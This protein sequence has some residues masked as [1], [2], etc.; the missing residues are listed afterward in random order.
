MDLEQAMKMPCIGPHPMNTGVR[1]SLDAGLKLSGHEWD[2]PTVFLC[3]GAGCMAWTVN[4][5]FQ[6]V[7]PGEPPPGPHWKLEEEMPVD[8]RG[9]Q[10]WTR[11]EGHCH[12]GPHL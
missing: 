6:R 1:A 2:A 12:F 7:P 4:H 3:R 10:M 9:A 8:I 5:K 11:A